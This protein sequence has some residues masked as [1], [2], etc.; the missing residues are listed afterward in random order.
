MSNPAALIESGRQDLNL[1][2]LGPE[3]SPPG[4]DTVGSDPTAPD[5]PET[6]EDGCGERSDTDR[7]SRPRPAASVTFQAQR[8]LGAT[9]LLTVREVAERL[10]VCRATVYRLVAKGALAS[11][12]VSSGAIRIVAAS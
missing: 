12:R 4:S 7:V 8:T 11:I 10:R 5:V 1:R 3:G 9:R 6:A 2:P